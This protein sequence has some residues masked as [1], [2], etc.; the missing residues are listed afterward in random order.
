MK[1]KTLDGQSVLGVGQALSAS[2]APESLTGALNTKGLDYKNS[3]EGMKFAGIENFWGYVGN[4][5][6][7]ILSFRVDGNPGISEVHTAINNFDDYK[8][9]NFC[10][11]VPGTLGI[12]SDCVGTSEGGFIPIEDLDAAIDVEVRASSYS[13]SFAGIGSVQADI[14]NSVLSQTNC[15][16]LAAYALGS[17]GNHL[18]AERT[19]GLFSLHVGL[20][21]QGGGWSGLGARLQK[22]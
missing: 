20:Y 22:L 19:I 2:T 12:M 16:G 14:F 10:C 5:V 17:T 6:D 7:G 11:I 21:Y 8:N 1:Y 3:G 13:C 15:F 4:F 9:Y 18:P